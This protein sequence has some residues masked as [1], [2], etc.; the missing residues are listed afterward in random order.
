MPLVNTTPTLQSS[1]YFPTLNQNSYL[2]SLYFQPKTQ[3]NLVFGMRASSPTTLKLNCGSW[4]LNQFSSSYHNEN[5][6]HSLLRKFPLK[7]LNLSVVLFFLKVFLWFTWFSFMLASAQFNLKTI[8]TPSPQR[9]NSKI[10]VIKTT[11]RPDLFDNILER[12]KAIKIARI[13]SAKIE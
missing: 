5:F 12:P 1:T 7:V 9:T 4:G 2:I 13:F 6:T 3:K 10:Y 11:P 8:S